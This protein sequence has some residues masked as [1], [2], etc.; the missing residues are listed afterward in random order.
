MSGEDMPCLVGGT[1][2]I[3]N[4]TAPKTCWTLVTHLPPLASAARVRW[5][6]G[7]RGMAEKMLPAFSLQ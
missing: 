1:T 4:T 2:R 7:E 6:C 5:E 3:Q